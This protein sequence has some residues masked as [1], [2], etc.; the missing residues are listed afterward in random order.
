M[1]KLHQQLSRWAETDLA[2][3]FDYTLETWGERQFEKYRALLE[4]SFEALARD[5]FLIQS[6]DRSELFAG[7]RSLHVGR[8]LILYRVKDKTLQIARVLHDTMELELHIP[9]ELLEAPPE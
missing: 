7:C 5:P 3:I 9:S 8:H 6:N 4:E 2:N 1:P